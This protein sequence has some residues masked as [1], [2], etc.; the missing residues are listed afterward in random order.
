MEISFQ[1]LIKSLKKIRDKEGPLKETVFLESFSPTKGPL[2]TI[3]LID[4][5][6]FHSNVNLRYGYTTV[7]HTERSELCSAS[8]YFCFTLNYFL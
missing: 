6:C 4:Q 2:K 7:H 1:R 8:V 3:L 5:L